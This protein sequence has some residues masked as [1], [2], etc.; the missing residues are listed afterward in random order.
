MT[1][2]S[3]ENQIAAWE[4]YAEAKRRADRTLRFE[5]GADAIRAWKEFANVFLPEDRQLPLD[6]PRHTVAIFPMH[7][8]RM[9]GDLSRRGHRE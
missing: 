5:D 9:S 6:A 3:T 2:A 8:T 1:T 7:K 4:R